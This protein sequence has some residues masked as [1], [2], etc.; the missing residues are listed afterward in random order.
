[1]FAYAKDLGAKGDGVAAD[2][3]KLTIQVMLYAP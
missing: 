1:M 3:E 2:T